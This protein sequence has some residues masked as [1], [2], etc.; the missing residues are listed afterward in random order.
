MLLLADLQPIPAYIEAAVDAVLLV[1]IVFPALYFFT[2][3][4][5]RIHI[6]ARKK[7]AN[8]QEKLITELHQALTEVKALSGLLPICASCKKIRDDKGY[9]NQIEKYISAHSDAKFSHGICPECLKKLYPE[10]ADKN[11]QSS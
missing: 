11:D 1:I 2:F 6:A 4:P 3:K 7:A 9:W 5:L 8:E 10:F